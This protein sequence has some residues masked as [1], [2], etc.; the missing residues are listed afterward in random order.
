MRERRIARLQ[1]QLK[2]RIAEV[3]QRE[4][5]DPALGLVTITRVELDAEFTLCRAYWSVL[6]GKGDR[7]RNERTLER[8]RAFVQREMSRGLH[9]RTT[10][11]LEFV[12]DQ[13]IEGAVR[14]Q[15]ILRELR[16]E[17]ET[18]GEPTPAPDGEG[19]D[20]PRPGNL[21]PDN[22]DEDDTGGEGGDDEEE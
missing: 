22:P 19:E 12:F 20:G 9:T 17:R 10:P 2:Q 16:E 7:A 21:E 1:E 6:G 15:G 14:V 13:S 18:R 5:R 8:A 4:L 11:R 3:L